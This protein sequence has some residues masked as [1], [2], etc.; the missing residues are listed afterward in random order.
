MSYSSRYQSNHPP[1][2][3]LHWQVQDADNAKSTHTA[4]AADWVG[5]GGGM[6][7]ST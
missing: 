4:A 1:T 3:S 6:N 5:G 7:L 2:L